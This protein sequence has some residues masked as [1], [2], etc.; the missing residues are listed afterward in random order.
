[1][2]FQNLVYIDYYIPVYP[3]ENRV[4]EHCLKIS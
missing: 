2:Y 3:Y 1:M 4:R